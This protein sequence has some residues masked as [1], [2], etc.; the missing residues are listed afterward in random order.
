[1]ISVVN[2]LLPI[3]HTKGRT[4]DIDL[5]VVHVTE[6]SAASVRSWFAASIA[7]VSAHY[8]VLVDG[9]IEQFVREEDTAWHAGRVDRA[10]ASLVTSRPGVNPNVYSIGIEHEGTG[11][12]PL[13]RAQQAASAALIRDICQ[14]RRIPIDRTHIVG[15]HEIFAPKTCPGAISVD[16]LVGAVLAS[17]ATRPSPPP[18]VWSE[19][20]NDWLIVTRVV[21][22]TEWY[23]VRLGDAARLNETKSQNSLATMQR[24]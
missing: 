6:G 17:G 24:V 12:L 3:N 20:L 7:S 18:V 1:M 8:M 21:S 23:F 13:T 16:A 2:R 14:R 5:I 9:T 15:H 10:T 22:D 11:K 19:F 4:R